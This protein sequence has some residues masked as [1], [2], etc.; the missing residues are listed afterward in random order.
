MGGVLLIDEAYSLSS[1]SDKDFAK[2][3]V[4]LINMYLSEHA[5]EMACIIAGYKKPI[6]EKPHD[7]IRILS[8]KFDTSQI[9]ISEPW[10]YSKYWINF[11]L[12]D[13]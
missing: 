1:T 5:H 13:N 3:S 7:F 4:D 11:V 8:Q 12:V 10:T 6:Y 9:W 2:E